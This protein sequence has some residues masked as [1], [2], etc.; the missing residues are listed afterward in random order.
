MVK[1][2]KDGNGTTHFFPVAVG[3]KTIGNAMA[4]VSAS[5]G[6]VEQVPTVV[7][8]HGKSF[9]NAQS[10]ENYL[11]SESGIWDIRP[12]LR[13]EKLL[14]V[15]PWGGPDSQEGFAPFFGAAALTA[16]IET[17]MRVAIVHGA[18]KRPEVV[19]VPYPASLVL[20]AHSGGGKALLKAAQAKTPYSNLLTDVWA[21]DCMYWGEAQDWIKWCNSS[22]NGKRTLHVRAAN[23]PKKPKVQADEMLKTPPNNA[24]IQIV[25]VGHF[26]MPKTF[27][28]EFV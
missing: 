9:V 4:F 22:G 20:A 18:V 28:P 17:A 10:L 23:K 7:Y 8:F 26:D 13:T 16:L 15:A 21:L 6:H 11:G 2:V 14:V 27:A 3:K 1:T 24:D 25:E 12:V 5:T 19:E